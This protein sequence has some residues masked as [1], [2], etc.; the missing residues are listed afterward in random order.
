M[1][2]PKINQ[3]KKIDYLMLRGKKEGGL[4]ENEILSSPLF[5]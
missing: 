5:V 3:D 4:Q 1:N 2:N